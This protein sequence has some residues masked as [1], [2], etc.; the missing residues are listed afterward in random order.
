MNTGVTSFPTPRVRPNARHAL[1]GIW[2]LTARRFFGPGYWLML[3]GMLVALVVFSVPWTQDK[4]SAAREFLRWAGGFYVC[5]LLPMFAFISA[6]GA[7][8]DD[9]GGGT[10]DYVFTRPVRRPVYVLFRYLAQLGCN[11]IDALF[12]LAGVIA[13]GA[14]HQVPGLWSALPVLLLAQVIALVVFSA[15]GLF[16]GALTSRYVIVGL[17]YAAIV[18]VGLGNVPTQI[19]QVSLVRQVM[20]ILQPILGES[21]PLGRAAQ[22]AMFDS[23][24]IVALLAAVAAVFV[25]LAA[26]LFTCREFAGAGGKDA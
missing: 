17:V 6:A 10:V 3:A 24:G 4:D 12:A 1:G 19:S 21:G 14:Y 22:T 13:I 5:F 7:I 20:G 16:C 18:E 23:P 2:R 9:L 25:A 11:Q 15:F 8:R 26:I